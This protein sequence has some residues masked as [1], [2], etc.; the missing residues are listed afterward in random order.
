MMLIS[1]RSTLQTLGLL[2][3]LSV[4]AQA[5]IVAVVSAHSSVTRLS[6]TQLADIFLGKV[7]RF[8]DGTLA[9]P[10]DLG[11]GSAERDQFYA[12]VTGKT[13]AQI[14]A[15]WSKVIFTGRGQPPKAVQNG[16]DMKQYVA[17]NIDAIGYIDS[18]MLDDSVRVLR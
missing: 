10:I 5:D 7:S 6:T 16:S 15:Y 9:V 11:D 4:Q 14:K 1:R 12:K 8:P 3:S 17:S 13:P 2:L 18:T